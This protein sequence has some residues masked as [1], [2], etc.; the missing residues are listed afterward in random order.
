MITQIDNKIVRKVL[1]LEL[2]FLL[3]LSIWT[4]FFLR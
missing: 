4:L 2:G 3:M 1:L